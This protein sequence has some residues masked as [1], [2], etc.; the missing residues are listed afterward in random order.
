ML[1]IR[2]EQRVADIHFPEFNRLFY[3]FYFRSV[4]EQTKRMLSKKNKDRSDKQSLFLAENDGW[5][6]HTSPGA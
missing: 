4:Q 2:G 5:I 1:A 6:G 3:H